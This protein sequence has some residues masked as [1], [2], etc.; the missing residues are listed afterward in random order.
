MPWVG[1]LQRHQATIPCPPRMQG[2]MV[3]QRL[4]GHLPSEGLHL[5]HGGAHRLWEA[6]VVEGRGIGACCQGGFMDLWP[7]R[8]HQTRVQGLTR[9]LERRG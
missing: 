3:G 1:Y 2:W 9:V 5:I 4:T 6:V 7:H 8:K